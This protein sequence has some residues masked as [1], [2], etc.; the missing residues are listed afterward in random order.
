MESPI[1][2]VPELTSI[3]RVVEDHVRISFSHESIAEMTLFQ[4]RES[5]LR[6]LTINR[7]K[8]CISHITC[9]YHRKK[10]TCQIIVWTLYITE[11]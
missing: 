7:I 1:Y 9:L 2:T 10:T 11:R 8:T 4:C 6:S 3:V 5:R